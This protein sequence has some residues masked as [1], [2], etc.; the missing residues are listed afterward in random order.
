MTWQSLSYYRQFYHEYSSMSIFA[1]EKEHD[2][3]YDKID[4]PTSA[5]R[6]LRFKACTPMPGLLGVIL[7]ITGK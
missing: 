6:V 5:P 1:A 7:G 4:P 3:M 2:L